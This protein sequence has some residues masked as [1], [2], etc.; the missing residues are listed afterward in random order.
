LRILSR[1]GSYLYENTGDE[2]CASLSKPLNGTLIVWRLSAGS[3][4]EWNE[5]DE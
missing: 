5:I 4:I 2:T 3:A 1:R